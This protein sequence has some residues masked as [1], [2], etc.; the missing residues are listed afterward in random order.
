[1]KKEYIVKL[2]TRPGE[3]KK[4]N[5]VNTEDEL[6]QIICSDDSYWSSVEDQIF[7]EDEFTLGEN[8]TKVDDPGITLA[9]IAFP[10]ID[11]IPNNNFG[12][13]DF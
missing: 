1:M 10:L 11:S 5:L 6:D 12:L 9:P 13:S 4:F 3:P 2:I 8:P 7:G